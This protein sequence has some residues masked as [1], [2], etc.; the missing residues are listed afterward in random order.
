MKKAERAHVD[1]VAALGCVACFVQAGVWVL[2]G[3]SSY[4]GGAGRGATRGWFEVLCLCPGHHRN[5]DKKSGKIAIHGNTGRK[6]FIAEY[7]SESEL[8]ELT[9]NNI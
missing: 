3:N 7:G 2:R 6:S 5:D 8:L 4:K 9:L 1:K